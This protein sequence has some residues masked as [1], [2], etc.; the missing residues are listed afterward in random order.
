MPKMAIMGPPAN[1]LPTAAASNIL[2]PSLEHRLMSYE[3]ERAVRGPCKDAGPLSQ[4][5]DGRTKQR[6]NI[7]NELK[8]GA[9]S[10]P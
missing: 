1:K 7:R 10:L 9:F 3:T 6:S 5:E 8:L 4:E 2:C